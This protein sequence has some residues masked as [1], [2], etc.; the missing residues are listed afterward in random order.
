[1]S[2]ASL[3]ED[4]G[5][6]YLLDIDT[7]RARTIH[8]AQPRAPSEEV[9]TLPVSAPGT[10]SAVVG[11]VEAE[12]GMTITGQHQADNDHAFNVGQ[13]RR[14]L[15]TSWMVIMPLPRMPASKT[16]HAPTSMV[17]HGRM[18]VPAVS[19][20]WNSRSDRLASTMEGLTK[21]NRVAEY[22][23]TAVLPANTVSLFS[24]EAYSTQRNIIKIMAPLHLHNLWIGLV[25]LGLLLACVLVTLILIVGFGWIRWTLDEQNTEDLNGIVVASILGL[26]LSGVFWVSVLLATLLGYIDAQYLNPVGIIQF[27]AFSSAGVAGGFILW[28]VRRN[29]IQPRDT[30]LK[31]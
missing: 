2:G 21:S 6:T 8:V 27:A 20:R 18:F 11:L 14:M 16:S 28:R 22:S 25:F 23:R 3:I 30:S 10:D 31:Q 5:G 17:L 12:N 29:R 26:S 4:G 19:G 9:R 13:C 7:N 24:E 15:Q 1:M